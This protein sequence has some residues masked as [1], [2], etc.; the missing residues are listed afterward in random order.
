M[1]TKQAYKCPSCGQPVWAL[2]EHAGTL[3]CLACWIDAKPALVIQLRDDIADMQERLQPVRKAK[4]ESK[5][6]IN[7]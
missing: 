2:I 5:D 1:A 6:A 3:Q 4:E 7:F